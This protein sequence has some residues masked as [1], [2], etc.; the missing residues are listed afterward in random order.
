MELITTK[1]AVSIIGCTFKKFE[2]YL[3]KRVITP[4]KKVSGRNYFD[5]A[6]VK[7]FVPPPKRKP[8]KRKVSS[9]TKKSQLQEVIEKWQVHKADTNSAD[10]Q[11]GIH[12]EKITQIE[13]EMKNY[14]REDSEFSN[15]RKQLVKHVVERRRLLNYLE[16]T[17]YSR[18]RRAVERIYPR[19]VA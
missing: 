17:N 2:K 14:S 8:Q 10:V 18:F 11:I 6:V 7:S 19:K 15:L 9:A 3:S 13:L 12:T 1:E 5:K 4:N 16:K